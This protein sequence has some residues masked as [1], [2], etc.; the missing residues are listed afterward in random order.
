MNASL[1]AYCLSSWCNALNTI[2]PYE[3]VIEEPVY[4]PKYVPPV[5]TTI[6]NA[7]ISTATITSPASTPATLISYSSYPSFMPPCCGQCSLT[8]E[9]GAQVLYWPTPAPEPPVSSIV[10]ANGFTL[11]VLLFCELSKVI[12]VLTLHTAYLLLYMSS[13]VL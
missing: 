2:T 11:Y 1:S 9:S 3:T 12:K 7:T 13:S 6:T 5:T 10:D 8:I 4:P